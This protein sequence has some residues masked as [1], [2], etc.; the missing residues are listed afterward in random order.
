MSS[1][2]SDLRSRAASELALILSGL[3][4]R[5]WYLGAMRAVERSIAVRELRTFIQYSL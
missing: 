4:F 5:E 1:V 2:K 3:R